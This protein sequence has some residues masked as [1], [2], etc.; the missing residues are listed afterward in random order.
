MANEIQIASRLHRLSPV[1]CFN[2]RRLLTIFQS[3][4][5]KFRGEPHLRNNNTAPCMHSFALAIAVL[6]SNVC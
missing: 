2:P 1:L 3:R 4:R 6:D 5:A